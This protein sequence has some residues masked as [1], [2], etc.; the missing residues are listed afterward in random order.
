[1]TSIPAI[2][3]LRQRSFRSLFSSPCFAAFTAPV[4]LHRAHIC[5]FIKGPWPRQIWMSY[6]NAFHLF[7]NTQTSLLLSAT[8]KSYILLKLCWLLLCFSHSHQVQAA[9]LKCTEEL[10]V[11]SL[12]QFPVQEEFLCALSFRDVWFQGSG[13]RRAEPR[14]ACL[15]RFHTS[16]SW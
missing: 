16:F 8:T 5:G 1:M 15:A 3:L 11:T 6:F 9:Y 12:R 14:N 10:P 7:P 2:H 4:L 13:L